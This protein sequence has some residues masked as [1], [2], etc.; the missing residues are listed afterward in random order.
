M[1][2][3]TWCP[4]LSLALVEALYLGILCSLNKLQAF[5]FYQPLSAPKLRIGRSSRVVVVVV[6]VER[7]RELTIIMP[8]PAVALA[9]GQRQFDM[10]FVHNYLLRL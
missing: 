8:H 2:L 7:E 9:S 6:I 4:N 5:C 1:I 10:L 3:L